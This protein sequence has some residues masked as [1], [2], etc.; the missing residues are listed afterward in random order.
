MFDRLKKGLT[1]TQLRTVY[2]QTAQCI[3]FGKKEFYSALRICHLYPAHKHFM[4]NDVWT[5]KSVMRVT[6][7]HYE[8]CF[9]SD[10]EQLS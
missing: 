4:G 9:P 1:F 10:S 7:Q 8:V 6:V 2:T 5:E 3:E